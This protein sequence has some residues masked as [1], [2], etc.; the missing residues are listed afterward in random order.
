MKA[1][2]HVAHFMDLLYSLGMNNREIIIVPFREFIQ[3]LGYLHFV[4][5]E[6]WSLSFPICILIVWSFYGKRIYLHFV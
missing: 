5:Y 4:K 6:S 3:S 2:F 1:L